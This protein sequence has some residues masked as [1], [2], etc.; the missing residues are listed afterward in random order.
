MKRIL[1][2]AT[3]ALLSVVLYAQDAHLKF[4]GIPVDGN[5]KAFAQKLVAKGFKQMEATDDGIVLVGNF[6][7]TPD[8][9]VIVYP[10]PSTKIVFNVSAML[11]AGDSWPLIEKKFDEIVATYKE[12]Y[13][14]PTEYSEEFAP[15]VVNS[16]YYRRESIDNGQCYYKAV[17]DVEGG[18][19]GIA[20][21]YFMLKYYIICAYID[22][23]NIKAVRKTIIDDI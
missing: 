3:V 21:A 2:S 9:M 13:G 1:L 12:K 20:P 18:R 22:D 23:E 5:Y 10:D 6:M 17:W 4:K 15:G 19:I 14:E 11:E 16:D 7:A 8:V